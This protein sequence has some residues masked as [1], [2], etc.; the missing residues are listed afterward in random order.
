MA[1]TSLHI[2]N[3]Y[4]PTSGGIRTFY[5]ALLD[6]ANREGRPVRLLVPGP[7]T[8][9]Q[10]VGRFG[11]V[12]FV[13]APRAPAF[14]RRYRLILPYTYFPILRS[15]VV[16]ILER[17]RPS[18]VEINDKYSLPY[19]AAMLRKGW[20]PR[21]PRPVLVGLSCERFDD[22]MSAYL[23]RSRAAAAFTRWYIRNIYGPP[24]DTHIAV[25]EYAARELRTVLHDRAP[26]FIRV[27][28]MGV[29]IDGF[30]P[31]RRS[32]ELRRR[33]LHQ[34]GGREDSVLLFYAGRLSPEK[35]VTL[36]VEML[37]DLVRDDGV[38]YRLVLA[39]DGPCAKWLRAQTTGALEGRILLC[40]TLD[41]EAL[42][43]CC[44][45]VDVFVHPNPREPFGIGPLEAMAS[46]VPVV[47]P[48]AGGVLEYASHDN[49]WLADPTAASMASAVRA[50]RHGDERRV[51][52][53]LATTRRFEWRNVTRRYFHLYDEICSGLV[54]RLPIGLPVTSS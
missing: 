30:G 11:R 52:S 23:S 42:A 20:L 14:D 38:D 32:V 46:G 5:N 50:A 9:V 39:G 21:V 28:G 41:R 8:R 12:Y 19:L 45:S 53:A 31:H 34:A 49:A 44:A 37:A 29:D 10:Q 48:A 3:A 54:E 47:V 26:D 24:F 35:N 43:S 36:F 4:H 25:S 6:A 33:L 15:A 51:A 2:T 17:E 16:E 7:E 1:M 27:C 13:R 22:N 40:G 18:L